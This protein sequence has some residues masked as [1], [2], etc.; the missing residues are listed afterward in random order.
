MTKEDA[1]ILVTVITPVAI[2][3]WAAVAFDITPRTGLKIIRWLIIIGATVGRVNLRAI[4]APLTPGSLR[5]V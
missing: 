3:C 2:L 5:S 4:L 1:I